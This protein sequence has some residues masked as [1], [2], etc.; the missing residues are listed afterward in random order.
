[1]RCCHRMEAFW[2][3]NDIAILD[4]H[5]LVERSIL[6]INA[7]EAEALRRVETVII[8]F[9]KIGLVRVIVGIVF[10]GRVG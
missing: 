7:L 9:L 6:R 5:R 2:Y 3:K 8:S 10:V 1:M 4:R